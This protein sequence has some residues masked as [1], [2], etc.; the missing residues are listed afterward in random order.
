MRGLL[1]DLDMFRRKIGDDKTRFLARALARPP[2]G[3][4]TNIIV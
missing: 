2:L 4:M 1:R 3:E